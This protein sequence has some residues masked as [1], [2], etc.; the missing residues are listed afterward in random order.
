VHFGPGRNQ[1]ELIEHGLDEMFKGRSCFWLHCIFWIAAAFFGWPQRFLDSKKCVSKSSF[2]GRL[3]VLRRRKLALATRLL[4]TMLEHRKAYRVRT[5]GRFAMA[6]V[7]RRAVFRA[8]ATL[9][10]VTERCYGG[11]GRISGG[12]RMPSR[13][14]QRRFPACAD[15]GM[16]LVRWSRHRRAARAGL[17]DFILPARCS[18]W[19]ALCRPNGNDATDR[20]GTSLTIGARAAVY[21]FCD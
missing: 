19:P 17:R 5:C 9:P 21:Y 4:L 16:V 12:W 3:F 18:V 14:P 13:K 20:G 7:G 8:R 10:I 6:H 15:C 2:R 1:L 11:T